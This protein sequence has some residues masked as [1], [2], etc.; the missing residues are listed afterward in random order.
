MTEEPQ[1]SHKYFIFASSSFSRS[2]VGAGEQT[3][4]TA[5]FC[6]PYCLLYHGQMNGGESW[7][8]HLVRGRT[9]SFHVH[10]DRNREDSTLLC[11]A[12]T[13]VE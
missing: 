9:V 12:A 3:R 10:S 8:I 13:T 5:V 11:C 6:K 2:G 1:H 4:G 7:M